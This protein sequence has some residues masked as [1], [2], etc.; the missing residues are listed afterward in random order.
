MT[1]L[2]SDNCLA[3]QIEGQDIKGRIIRLNKSLNAVLGNHS[4]PDAVKQQLGQAMAL[5]AMLGSMMKFDGILTAQ[6][7]SDGLIRTLVSDYATGGNGSGVVRGYCG[8]DEDA[9][10]VLGDGQLMITIDQGQYMDRYQ[11][12]VK[13]EGN[14][15]KNSAEEYFLASEQL[16]THLMI[17]CDKAEDGIWTAAAIMI[18]HLARST[19]DEREMEIHAPTERQDNW[20]T[21]K[22]L[23]SSV[24]PT[25]LLDHD[26]SLQDLLL[27]LFNESGVRVFTTTEM[28][29]GCRCSEKKLRS[30]LASFSLDELKDCAE[31][32]VITMTCEFCMTDHTFELDKLI[33]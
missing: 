26:L 4:Y 17:S 12:I 33:N 30:V 7:K 13:L 20:N 31:D 25:E 27:R 1:P 5:T 9:S 18:Q 2:Y 29:T 24:K 3:F 28:I 21:A 6:I 32:G 23:L 19:V 14:S 11:G 8:L 16:P 15:L 10:P 22:I